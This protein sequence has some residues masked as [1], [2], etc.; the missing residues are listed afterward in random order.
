[1]KITVRLYATLRRPTA[2]GLQHEV[3]VDLPPEA[4]LA[5]LL[6][7]LNLGL[8]PEHLLAVVNR[9]RLDLHDRL[10][11]GNEVHLFPPISG[12]V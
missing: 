2:A 7:V 8:A 12:G 5:D 11:P 1:L 4:T 10:H 9:R 3:V 6:Q